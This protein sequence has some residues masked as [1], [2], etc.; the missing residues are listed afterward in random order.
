MDAFKYNPDIS[1]RTGGVYKKQLVVD[2]LTKLI[3]TVAPNKYFFALVPNIWKE[4]VLPP[5]TTEQSVKDWNSDPMQFW[6]NQIN[7]A[8][9]CATA[10]CGVSFTDHLKDTQDKSLLQDMYIFHV[11]Y[12]TRKILYELGVAAPNDVGFDPI[13]N[14]YDKNAYDRICSEF[15]VDSATNW[16]QRIFPNTDGLGDVYTHGHVVWNQT[17]FRNDNASKHI[18]TRNANNLDLTKMTFGAE[19]PGGR[20]CGF[21]SCHNLPPKKAH[22]DNIQQDP[23]VEGVWS[24]FV[25]DKSKGFTLAGLSRLDD[26]IRTYV[27][28]VLGSQ[29]HTRS[30]IVGQSSLYDA[31]KD[32]LNIIEASIQTSK[33]VA[34]SIAEYQGMLEYARGKVDYVFGQDLYMAP[35]DMILRMNN[36]IA[37][38]NNKIVIANSKLSLGINNLVNANPIKVPS[39]ESFTTPDKP[40]PVIHNPAIHKDDPVIH[41]DHLVIHKDDPVTHNDEKTALILGGVVV[42]LAVIWSLT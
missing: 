1:Y 24:T 30:R 17:D 15:K 35:S 4:Y 28:A 29:T 20:E 36:D 40:S 42:G 14:I 13:D 8:M 18:A 5:I 32:F 7:F 11:Y 37:G 38:Y 41:E 2:N 19:V 12:T 26:T 34:D 31:Q 27:R 9:W 25:L 33:T 23:G 10:G 21:S 39:N 16:R 6:Q 3:I 22:I